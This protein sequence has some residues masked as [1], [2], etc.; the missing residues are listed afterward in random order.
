MRRPHTQGIPHSIKSLLKATR[1]PPRDLRRQRTRKVE[2][3]ARW[4]ASTARRRASHAQQNNLVAVA[5]AWDR[6]STP[7]PRAGA[8]ELKPHPWS[9]APAAAECG[10]GAPMAGGSQSTATT[11]ARRR[12]AIS[13]PG[14]P[15]RLMNV[16]YAN[17]HVGISRPRR[18]QPARRQFA[19]EKCEPLASRRR[20]ERL[21]AHQKYGRFTLGRRCLQSGATF[22]G[23]R[24][25]RSSLRDCVG[26]PFSRSPALLIACV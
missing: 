9:N 18:E 15:R 7:E 22:R 20:D 10:H 24:A 21:A 6:T 23:L 2:R 3:V 12:R 13:T 11:P 19:V 8:T 16:P 14:A 25:A 1:N 5:I 4:S 17:A 26:I